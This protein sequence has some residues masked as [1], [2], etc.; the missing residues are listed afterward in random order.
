[1]ALDSH[2]VILIIY[3]SA[4]VGIIIAVGAYVY[5]KAKKAR[6]KAENL[7]DK[8]NLSKEELEKARKSKSESQDAAPGNFFEQVWWAREIYTAV[9][10]H[11]Y[12]QATDIAVMV[13]WGSLLRQELEGDNL[14]GVD[15]RAFFFPG[16]GFIMLYRVITMFFALYED[17]QYGRQQKKIKQL[18]VERHQD[19]EKEMMKNLKQKKPWQVI[20]DLTL[21][22]LDL[23]FIKVVYH[24]FENGE[25]RPNQTHRS[26]QLCEALFERF[27]VSLFLFLFMFLNSFFLSLHSISITM[28]ICL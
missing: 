23:Y 8:T 5:Y 14:E 22:A 19:L 4:Y 20:W 7:K 27:V 28:E 21:S 25:K 24:E 10:V 12:D 26:L 16:L 1:M 15:M 17:T 13:Q 6:E 11:I 3:A 9:I 2:Y 18:G